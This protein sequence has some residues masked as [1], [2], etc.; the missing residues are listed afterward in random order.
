MLAG[1]HSPLP[2]GAAADH[3]RNARASRS[4]L[5]AATSHHAQYAARSPSLAAS[6]P[7]NV[8]LT[9]PTRPSNI[10]AMLRR[11]FV[12]AQ[13][14]RDMFAHCEFLPRA[15]FRHLSDCF[16][17]MM[18]AAVSFSAVGEVVA[19]RGLSVT[20]LNHMLFPKVEFVF[21]AADFENCGSEIFGVVSLNGVRL[22]R[23]SS[24]ISIPFH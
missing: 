12:T 10:G 8:F 6:V 4:R 24:I 11:S 5:C 23:S 3:R 17:L 7:C 16:G 15:T 19:V 2:R 20:E 21:A 13:F 14:R 18:P 22:K 1:A 9:L